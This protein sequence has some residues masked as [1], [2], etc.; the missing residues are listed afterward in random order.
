MNTKGKITV[1]ELVKGT[2]NNGELGRTITGSTC[3]YED[4]QVWVSRSEDIH[5][6]GNVSEWTS[7]EATEGPRMY[8]VITWKCH[9]TYDEG[10]PE[11]PGGGGNGGDWSGGSVNNEIPTLP[12]LPNPK[13]PCNKIKTQRTNTDFNGKITDLEGKTGLKKETGYIQRTNGQYTYKDNASATDQ[14]NELSLPRADL[15]ENKDIISYLHT[16]VN[17][18][19]YPDPQNPDITITKKGFKI[20]SPADVGYFMKMIKNA[21]DAGRPLGDVYAVL[22]SSIKNYQIRFTGN[23]YQIKTFTD[24]Q[25]DAFSKLYINFMEKY[26]KKLELGFLKFIDEKMNLKGI[27]LYRMNSDG[28]T[29]EIK[30]NTDKTDT[31]ETNCPL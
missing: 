15:P 9:Y 31:A 13:D 4:E 11:N 14:A 19:E 30:L 10:T 27:S 24:A 16:H 28:S 5:N 6:Q 18:Y 25:R 12:N 3:G 29:T 26:S 22:V 17:D 21:Q 20:F 2:F 8:T 1:N 23:Q 7:C